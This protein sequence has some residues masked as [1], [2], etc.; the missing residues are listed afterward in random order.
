VQQAFPSTAPLSIG[1]IGM[2]D[3]TTPENHPNGTHYYG[4]KIDVAYYIRP[5][6]QRSDGNLAY[7]QICC[8]A[9]LSDWSC[10]DLGSISATYG[11]CV[12]GSENTHI[13]DLPRTAMF[14][15]KLGST[16]RIRVIG[17]EAKVKPALIAELT[18]LEAQGL[19]TAAESATGKAIMVTALDDPS[20]IWHFHHM[21][22]SF[23]T[24][25]TSTMKVARGLWPDMPPSQQAARA[26]AFFEKR[27]RRPIPKWQ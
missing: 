4:A 16:G 11:T 22:V 13:V 20:W 15:A 24:D 1:D 19:I 10:V 21:H 18:D 17:T 6:V 5:D 8:D 3:G 14:I 12:A 25:P 7:R 27:T 26:R 23:K 9:P 2:P